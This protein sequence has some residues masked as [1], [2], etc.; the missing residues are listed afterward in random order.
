MSRQ[1]HFAASTASTGRRKGQYENSEDI[2]ALPDSRQC[3]A[4][5]KAKMP[6]RSQDDDEC[7]L[8]LM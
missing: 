7:P 5:R 4:D 3:T 2:Q 1:V 8:Y 6:Q